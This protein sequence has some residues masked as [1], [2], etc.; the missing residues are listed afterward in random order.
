MLSANAEQRANIKFLTKLGKSATETYNLLTEVYGDQCLSRTQVFE[1]F[2]KFMEGRKNVG[3]D[4][5][6]GRPPTAKTPEN[7]EKV[8]RIVRRDRRLSIRAISELTNINKETHNALSVKRYLA[9]N[10]IPVMEHPPY[11]PDLAPCDFFLF[12]KIKSALKGTRF[13]SVDAV[14]AKATQLL[15]SITQDDLQHCFQQWK[16][17][18]ER[19]RD[20]G[21]DYIEGDNISTV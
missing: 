17:R 19:C 6:S 13:E 8:A 7:V 9:K 15:K 2:K 5:K 16:I 11:S 18:M 14:K 4:P 3:N 20:R 1:W 21:G 10:N 12:P